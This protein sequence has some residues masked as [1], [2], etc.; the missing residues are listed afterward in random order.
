MICGLDQIQLACIGVLAAQ[1]CSLDSIEIA[2]QISESK[3]ILL[4]EHVGIAAQAKATQRA[5]QGLAEMGL[6]YD[7]GLGSRGDCRH[8]ATP[9]VARRSAGWESAEYG[10]NGRQPSAPESR[11][12]FGRRGH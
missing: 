2:A 7:M 11:T 8:W 5:L 6:V 10:K 1:D 3:P 12:L 9:N 4:S